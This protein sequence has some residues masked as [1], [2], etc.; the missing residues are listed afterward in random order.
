MSDDDAPKSLPKKRKPVDRA[1]DKADR[2]AASARS[3]ERIKPRAAVAPVAPPMDPDKKYGTQHLVMM[4]VGG[5]AV[6]GIG[7][8]LAGKPSDAAVQ[9]AKDTTATAQPA[10]ADKG[11]AAPQKA[12]RPPPPAGAYIPLASWTPREGPEHAKVTIIEFSDAQ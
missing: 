10:G 4:L 7:G 8:Y 6:G 9:A 1:V 2:P 5:L 3:P 12:P 11:T